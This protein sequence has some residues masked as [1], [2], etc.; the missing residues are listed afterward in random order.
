MNLYV[1][2]HTK[3]KWLKLSTT[4]RA[5][6]Q[7]AATLT[8]KSQK[9]PQVYRVQRVGMDASVCACSRRKRLE[10]STTNLVDIIHGRLPLCT[11]LEVKRS[12]VMM[13]TARFSSLQLLLCYYV[14]GTMEEHRQQTN[15]WLCLTV[16][17]SLCTCASVDYS[18]SRA[19]CNKDSMSWRQ[20]TLYTTKP[21]TTIHTVTLTTI[22]HATVTQLS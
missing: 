6:F 3:E 11:D 7:H 12:R 5:G 4:K 9:R 22:P 14:Q 13:A 18:S 8:S 17:H 2:L 16:F 19:T 20:I 1:W 10:I 15:I 21:T